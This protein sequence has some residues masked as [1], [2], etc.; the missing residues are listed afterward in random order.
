MLC[1]LWFSRKV[2]ILE[3]SALTIAHL[4]YPVMKE[5]GETGVLMSAD[6]I[7]EKLGEDFKISY[8]VRPDPDA[9]NDDKDRIRHLQLLR[10][11][12]EFGYVRGAMPEGR[13]A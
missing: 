8:S 2:I 5:V 11:G 6:E 10:Q 3:P 7:R 13:Y 4:F 1:Q 9:G 12:E